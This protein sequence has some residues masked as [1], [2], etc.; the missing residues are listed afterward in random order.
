MPINYIVTSDT[1]ISENSAFTITQAYGDYSGGNTFGDNSSLITETVLY[2]RPKINYKVMAENFRIAN[3]DDPDTILTPLSEYEYGE[4]EIPGEFNANYFSIYK[5]GENDCSFPIEDQTQGVPAI[6]KVQLTNEG[7]VYNGTNYIRVHISLNPEWVMP[8]GHTT[9]NVNINGYA[10]EV[11]TDLEEEEGLTIVDED[12]G[13]PDDITWPETGDTDASDTDGVDDNSEVEVI[14]DDT[15]DS[16]GDDDS[17]DDFDGEDDEYDNVYDDGDTIETGGTEDEENGDDEEENGEEEINEEV[18]G[19]P[20]A[21]FTYTED[22]DNEHGLKHNTMFQGNTGDSSPFTKEEGD[23]LTISYTLELVEDNINQEWP[24]YEAQVLTTLGGI[25]ASTAM[26]GNNSPMTITKTVQ[27]G[28]A[29]GDGNIYDDKV[30]ITFPNTNALAGAKILLSN[31]TCQV[32]SSSNWNFVDNQPLADEGG[33][34]KFSYVI[35]YNVWTSQLNFDMGVSY[36]MG[37]EIQGTG[38]FPHI[39][40]WRKH[41]VQG[42]WIYEV[43]STYPSGQSAQAMAQGFGV[44]YN[45]PAPRRQESR[46]I[47]KKSESKIGNKKEWKISGRMRTNKFLRIA[48]VR[49]K[50]KSGYYFD[51]IP[52]I[53]NQGVDGDFNLRLRG[54]RRDSNG[55]ISTY[56]F[57]LLYK[58]NKRKTASSPNQKL[59]ITKKVK[60]NKTK[61]T[62]IKSI[63]FGKNKISPNGGFKT[64]EVFG[65][66]GAT[67]AYT[68][69]RNSSQEDLLERLETDSTIPFYETTNTKNGEKI[70]CHYGVIPSNG[71]YSKRLIVPSFKVAQT[72]LNGAMSN[73]TTM[74]L[75]STSGIKVGDKIYLNGI[76]KGTTIT[77]SNVAIDGVTLTTSANITASDNA[78]VDFGRSDEYHLMFYKTITNGSTTTTLSDWGSRTPTT[79]PTFNTK[80]YVNPL[81]IIRGTETNANYTGPADIVLTGV[82]D[83]IVGP[84]RGIRKLGKSSFKINYRFVGASSKNFTVLKTPTFSNSDQSASDW[85]N[86]VYGDNSGTIVEINNIQTSGHGTNVVTLTADANVNKWGTEDTTMVLDLDTVFSIS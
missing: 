16:N 34:P 55:N 51:E 6:N 2:I 32:Y 67:L 84:T 43:T 56:Y 4:E 65:T 73:T 74:V 37:G 18:T 22:Q 76:A 25:E 15:D 44:N 72:R 83:E 77:V 35:N 64:L 45:P 60:K 41:S 69:V 53:K 86:S 13:I 11:I 8:Q 48:R 36:Q 17:G 63:R 9:V 52:M 33:E 10:E 78:A 71:R 82:G 57:Y 12:D 62:Q 7:D 20:W 66:P 23:V 75:D 42:D 85:T 54:A 80:Q 81:L 50:A 30:K 1:S 68:F 26:I 19:G 46:I 24:G 31:V 14:T 38:S 59:I 58:K 70:N 61:V 39:D 27:A 29:D 5:E 3:I 47:I 40:G 28:A 79:S 49:V 21:M